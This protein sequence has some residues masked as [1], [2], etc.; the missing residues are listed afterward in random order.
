MALKK[1]V[2]MILDILFAIIP[3]IPVSLYLNESLELV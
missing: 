2:S 3:V 1:I